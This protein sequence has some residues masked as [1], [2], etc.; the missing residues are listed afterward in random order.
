M[1]KLCLLLILMFSTISISAQDCIHEY[2][3]HAN[4]YANVNLPKYRQHLCKEYRMSHHDLERC[5]NK[6]E[7]N[8]G[9]VGL[10]LEIA[11]FAD[12]DVEDICDYYK[13]YGRHGWKRVLQEIGIKPG[14][15]HYNPLIHRIS[16]CGRYWNDCYDNHRHHSDRH[17]KHH[18]RH[19][20]SYCND[21]CYDRDDD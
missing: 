15:R 3:R 2:V 13:E 14:S 5:Y 4:R 8:W 18:R 7:R 21:D 10:A 20:K 19:H 1:K 11:R 12:R 16:E 9:N 17:Y 6:C